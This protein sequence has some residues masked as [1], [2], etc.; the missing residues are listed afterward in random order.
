MHLRAS[1]IVGLKWHVHGESLQ[2]AI[3]WDA[4]S[5]NVSSS[6]WSPRNPWIA[7]SSRGAPKSQI[8]SYR[9]AVR[10]PASGN[11]VDKIDVRSFTPQELAGASSYRPDGPYR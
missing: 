4:D 10:V 7:H 11:R 9:V 3:E 6:N 5:V 1:W 8:D 2:V